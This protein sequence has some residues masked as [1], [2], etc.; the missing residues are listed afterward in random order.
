MIYLHKTLV[1]LHLLAMATLIGG[2]TSQMSSLQRRITPGQWHGSM[3]A[4][5]TGLALV[6]LAEMVPGQIT[7]P[8]HAKVAVKLTIGMALVILTWIGHRKNHWNKGW[9]TTGLLAVINTVVAVAW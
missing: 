4:V 8:I 1:I 3:L 2:F 9:L 5:A 6:A 7:Q